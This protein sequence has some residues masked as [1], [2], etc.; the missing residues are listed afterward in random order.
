MSQVRD[1][2]NEP[3][4]KT[5][6]LNGQGSKPVAGGEEGKPSTSRVVREE[7]ESSSS[8]S[9]WSSSIEDTDSSS[10]SDTSSAGSN[11][12][13]MKPVTA[14]RASSFRLP[15]RLSEAVVKPNGVVVHERMK[16]EMMVDVVA[17]KSEHVINELPE[18]LDRLLTPIHTKRMVAMLPQYPAIMK[19]SW[20]HPLLRSSSEMDTASEALDELV[21]DRGSLMFFLRGFKKSKFSVPLMSFLIFLTSVIIALVNRATVNTDQVIFYTGTTILSIVF[22]TTLA[23]VEASFICFIFPSITRTPKR[24]FLT[25]L[26][27][28]PYI[29]TY[30]VCSP[31]QLSFNLLDFIACFVVP[32]AVK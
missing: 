9:S 4:A 13:E 23:I 21:K 3:Q 2:A 22:C 20:P 11:G 25:V 12:V 30:I 17:G 14:F 5:A 27:M 1:E 19:F 26:L 32:S 6:N 15:D 16:L 29:L 18:N 10:F 31:S 7:Q 28:I 24:R 8:S